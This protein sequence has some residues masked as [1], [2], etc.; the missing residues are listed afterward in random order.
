MH[1]L[2]LTLIV[3]GYLESD[4]ILHHLVVAQMY[5]MMC[6]LSV[7]RNVPT[8]TEIERWTK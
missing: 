2:E 5:R 4:P 3:L 8:E 1:S 6:I 7:I